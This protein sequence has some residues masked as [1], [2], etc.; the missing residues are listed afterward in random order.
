[1]RNKIFLAVSTAITA[2]AICW[3]NEFLFS[4]FS[5]NLMV[6]GTDMLFSKNTSVSKEFTLVALIVALAGL[7]LV[8]MC[9]ANWNPVLKHE[10]SIVFGIGTFLEPF[11]ICM[12]NKYGEKIFPKPTATQQ[13]N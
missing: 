13:K 5:I 2:I 6:L 12:Y 8:A 1:M 4:A 10:E 7:S 11:V 9:I 3:N